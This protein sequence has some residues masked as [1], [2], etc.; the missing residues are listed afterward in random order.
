VGSCAAFVQ[1][2]VDVFGDKTS[3]D[4]FIYSSVQEKLIDRYAH[5]C[6]RGF[7]PEVLR[8]AV[9]KVLCDAGFAKFPII[10]KLMPKGERKRR[11]CGDAM[12]ICEGC[13][14]TALLFEPTQIA[15][16]LGLAHLHAPFDPNKSR[17][18]AKRGLKLLAE[19]RND[20]G[21]KAIASGGSDIIPADIDDRIQRELEGY[22][23]V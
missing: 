16:Y 6:K 21:S 11:E 1:L 19:T 10:G 3:I 2:V 17:D 18:F 20:P 22:L 4:V 15:G 8:A 7:S 5:L 9:S 12:M 14:E 23:A 13:F